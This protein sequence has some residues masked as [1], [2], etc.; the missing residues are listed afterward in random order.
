M[1]ICFIEYNWTAGVFQFR[2]GQSFT[3]FR[4]ERSWP[5]MASVKAAL[6][7]G[8]CRLGKKTDSR[9]WPVE[10]VESGQ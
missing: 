9:T 1:A 8:G 10:A 5:D 3:D 7:A 2:V 4:G 6:A